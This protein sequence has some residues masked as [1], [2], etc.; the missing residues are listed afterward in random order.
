MIGLVGP[1]SVSSFYVI[2]DLKEGGENA[3]LK[4]VSGIRGGHLRLGGAI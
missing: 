2:G 1:C 4:Q 3:K